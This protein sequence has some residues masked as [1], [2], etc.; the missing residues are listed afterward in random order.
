MEQAGS[1]V[2]PIADAAILAEEH[3]VVQ[4]TEQR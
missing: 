2:G 3:T 4:M 1:P